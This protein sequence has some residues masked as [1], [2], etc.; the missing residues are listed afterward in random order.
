[1]YG[2]LDCG[3]SSFSLFA[4]TLTALVLVFSLS[5]KAQDEWISQDPPEPGPFGSDS[6]PGQIDPTGG[7]LLESI[8]TQ[9][10]PEKPAA[11]RPEK[12]RAAPAT[13][14]GKVITAGA[15]V[16]KTASFDGKVLGKLSA[17]KTF[18][19]SSKTVGPF[20]KLKVKEGVY[21][22]IADT[23]IRPI[24]TAKEIQAKKKAG[25]EKAQARQEKKKE[26]KKKKA[27]EFQKYRGLSLSNVN[28]R[29]ETMGLRPTETMLF[30]GA[31]FSGPDVLVQGG[32]VDANLLFHFGAP[33]YYSDA[34]GK[35][36]D[37]FALL[38]DFLFQSAMPQGENTLLM[39][40]FGPMFKYSK[41]SVALG[42]GGK[43]EAYDMIDMTVGVVLNAGLAQR[44]DSFALRGEIKYYWEKM[45]YTALGLSVQ[46]PF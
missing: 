25:L 43:E 33:K 41:Y 38:M 39:L 31:K 12:V 9:P 32:Y 28:F 10:A 14:R 35:S 19:I 21:G 27:F 5:L 37:G 40:G 15:L 11:T 3:H 8:K 4:R 46:L 2:S 17:G 30:Y 1:V 34:T 16:Y 22:Y 13:R 18:P 24:L 20:Y 36:A 26:Q 29:E 44:F 7:A 6:G 45:Q 42:V 23:D